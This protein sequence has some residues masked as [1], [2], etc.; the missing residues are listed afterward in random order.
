VSFSKFH[1]I[2]FNSTKI[3]KDNKVDI[4][5]ASKDH[6]GNVTTHVWLNAHAHY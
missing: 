2:N 6:G 5:Q 1:I 3:L 4:N